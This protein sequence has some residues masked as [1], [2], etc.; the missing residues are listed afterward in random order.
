[1]LHFFLINK[2]ID[3][4]KM[5]TAG[6]VTKNVLG[7]I[8]KGE[9]ASQIYNKYNLIVIIIE[10]RQKRLFFLIDFMIFS[11]ILKILSDN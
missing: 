4:I 1:M 9:F 10:S 8:V 2:S 11:V 5:L 7:G 3:E 6:I